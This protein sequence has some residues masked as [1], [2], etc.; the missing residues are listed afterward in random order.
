M[1]K[2]EEFK[3]QQENLK[4]LIEEMTQTLKD[5]GVC[6]LVFERF[7]VNPTHNLK[8]LFYKNTNHKEKYLYYQIEPLRYFRL[9]K[10]AILQAKSQNPTWFKLHTP[11]ILNELKTSKTDIVTSYD[12][13]KE[14]HLFKDVLHQALKKNDV[15]RLDDL[16]KKYALFHALSIFKTDLSNVSFLYEE[17]ARQGFVEYWTN[18]FSLAFY[19]NEL[20][21][22]SL[23]NFKCGTIGSCLIELL[24]ILKSNELTKYNTQIVSFIK[25]TAKYYFDNLNVEQK[26]EAI[27][28]LK[29]EIKNGCAFAWLWQEVVSEV[30]NKEENKKKRL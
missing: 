1:N 18:L 6:D 20:V 26:E 28:N 29:N 17:G 8:A 7:L 2:K 16:A 12:V 9:S 23:D 27:K 10:D 22:I 21:F 11:F 14:K 19:N 4:D 3:Q 30:D 5:N 15:I 25:N 24:W 13:L